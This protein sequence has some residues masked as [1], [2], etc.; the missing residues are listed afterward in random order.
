MESSLSHL[1]QV[2]AYPA[3]GRNSQLQLRQFSLNPLVDLIGRD[4]IIKKVRE[5]LE[6]E[7]FSFLVIGLDGKGKTVLYKNRRE[8]AIYTEF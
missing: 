7:C 6:K 2:T 4:D 1:Y 5:M 3:K 8:R